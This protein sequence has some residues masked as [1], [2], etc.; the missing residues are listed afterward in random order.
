[1]IL[2]DAYKA[3]V[4]YWGNGPGGRVQGVRAKVC[5]DF[6]GETREVG[7]LGVSDAVRLLTWMRDEE[8]S[9][10]SISAYYASF[11]RMLALSGHGGLTLTWP[12]APPQPRKSKREP[13]GEEDVLALV[14]WFRREGYP[15]T[16]DLAALLWGTGLRVDVEALGGPDGSSLR[17]VGAQ[18]DAERAGYETLEVTG[19]GGHQKVVPVVAWLWPRDA[20][21]ILLKIKRVIPESF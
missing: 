6:F 5:M 16:A 10:E 2:A 18:E 19:K 17:L 8:Y 9:A 13:L 1:M 12:K 14:T 21:R 7:T 4:A 20:Q 15:E 3:A 11:R